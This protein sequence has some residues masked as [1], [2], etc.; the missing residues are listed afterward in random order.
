MLDTPPVTPGRIFISYRQQDSAYP[1]GW[2][3]DRLAERFGNGQVF[4]DVDSIGLGAD[5]VEVITNAVA[6]CEVLL[7]VIGPSW[8]DARSAEGHRRLD[9]PNDFVR[10][11][12]ETALNRGV[13]VIPV[14]VGG[15]PIPK[16]GDLPASIARLVRHQ[17]LELSPQRFHA[18]AARLLEA[19]DRTLAG[20]RDARDSGGHEP[21]V[22]PPEPEPEAVVTAPE[23]DAGESAGGAEPETTA[24]VPS[25][26]RPP[27]EGQPKEPSRTRRIPVRMRIVGAVA[28]VAVLVG[29]GVLAVRALSNGGADSGGASGPPA[30]ASDVTS[31]QHR[32]A[33]PPLGGPGGP[34]VLAHRGGREKYAW[35]TMPAFLSSAHAGAAVETDVR[36][37]A[38]GVAVLVHDAGTTPG[39][40]CSGGSYTVAQ[41]SWAVL[42]DKC[43]S[44]AAASTDGK[45]YGIPTFQDAVTA[46][47]GIPGA[48]IFPEV[49][50]DQTPTQVR[51]FMGIL[52]NV[53]MT[54]RA[55]VTSFF[56]GELAKIRAQAREDGVRVRTMLFE[57]GSPLSVDSLAGQHLWGVAVEVKIAETGYV[58]DLQRSGLAV[59]IWL[60]NGRAQWRKAKR[61]GADLVLTDEPEAY[62]RW[63]NG[64]G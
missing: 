36:W 40:Q 6:S 29:G 53:R 63:A 10:L 52:E 12:I 62:G 33:S 41:T 4:K 3:Y 20:L 30:S 56:P 39:M 13:L 34:T 42:R 45:R 21:A 11:E 17:A 22:P 23:P 1:A 57:S 55:V 5:F 64:S 24:P 37:T 28:A 48:Q 44:P 7:A 25:P 2:L 61:L 54:D 60:V 31:G 15:T 26:V 47:A 14:L 50:V 35:Q 19:I 9:D 46:L 59:E 49:K 51:Q 58:K 32:S 38:D 18:D 43:R 8:L 27:P 16:P